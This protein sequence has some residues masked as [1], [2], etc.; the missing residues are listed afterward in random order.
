MK[1]VIVGL[2]ASVYAVWL[3]YAAGLDY[4]VLTMLLY[5]PG[6]ILYK[7]TKKE[8]KVTTPD[9][10]LDKGLMVL[11]VVLAVYAVFGLATGRITI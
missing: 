11:F 8:N 2:V 6:I 1:D 7:W 3:V 5:A 9:T 4:L 10:G